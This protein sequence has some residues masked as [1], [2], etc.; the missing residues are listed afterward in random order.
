MSVAFGGITPPAPEAPYPNSEGTIKVALEPSS[1]PGITLPTP[2]G[3]VIP[4]WDEGIMLLN[5]GSK[6]T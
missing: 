1:H 2:I 5:E 3:I 6:A 4:G